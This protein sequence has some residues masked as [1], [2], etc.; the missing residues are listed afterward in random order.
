MADDEIRAGYKVS[1]GREMADADLAAFHRMCQMFGCEDAKSY[2]EVKIK[3]LAAF[4]AVGDELDA[5]AL[6]SE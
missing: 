5:E 3:L 6:A 4:E 1:T 2:Q